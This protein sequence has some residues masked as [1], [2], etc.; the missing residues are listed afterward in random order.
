MDFGEHLEK[1]DIDALIEMLSA[2]NIGQLSSDDRFQQAFAFVT[3][4]QAA[5]NATSTSQIADL[6]VKFKRTPT[7][8]TFVFDNKAAPGFDE[9]VQE[10]LE[11]LYA[12]YRQERG[13]S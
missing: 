11:R 2:D 5:M 1:V 10:R 4:R 8:A 3:S 6:P 12:Q 7:T 13:A 9:F